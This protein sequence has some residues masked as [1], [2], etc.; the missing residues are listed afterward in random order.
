MNLAYIAKLD[1][2]IQKIDVSAQ[3]IDSFSL[4]ICGMVI[5]TFQV[6]NKLGC[7]QFF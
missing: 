5:T 2:Q 7:L 6:L 4:E 3:K 1:L